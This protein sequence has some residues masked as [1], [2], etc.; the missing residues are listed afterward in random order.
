M[1]KRNLPFAPRYCRPI[2]RVR[3]YDVYNHHCVEKAVNVALNELKQEQISAQIQK[4]SPQSVWARNSILPFT[5]SFTTYNLFLDEKD[6]RRAIVTA[7][8]VLA[9][10]LPPP[11]R[12]RCVKDRSKEDTQT[13]LKSLTRICTQVAATYI[14]SELITSDMIVKLPSHLKQ[15]LLKSAAKRHHLNDKLLELFK[16]R[17]YEKIYLKC[18]SI[19]NS[20]FAN[21]FDY[22]YSYNDEESWQ[23][24]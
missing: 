9:G 14:K 17:D 3:P 13:R 5:N 22:S 4:H 6:K 8:K 15:S 21:F 18:S 23:S 1:P 7:Q 24:H 10:P 12:T 20:G 2:K 16:D 11:P 19:T